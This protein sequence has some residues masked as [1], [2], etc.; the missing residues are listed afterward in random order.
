MASLRNGLDVRTGLEVAGI[1]RAVLDG[2]VLDEAVLDEA[3]RRYLANPLF[4]AARFDELVIDDNPYRR[5]VRPDDI[6][7]VDF[8]T[9]LARADFAQLSALMGHRML[10]NVHDADKLLLPRRT[11]PQKWDD[12]RRF[13]DSTNRQLGE[14]IRPHLEDHLFGFVREL[15]AAQHPVRSASE[16]MGRIDDLARQRRRQN[17]ELHDLVDRSAHRA[18]MLVMLAIQADAIALNAGH[19]ESS[20]RRRLLALSDQALPD[21][22]G[23]PDRPVQQPRQ[24][25]RFEPHSYYQYYL[26]STLALMNALNGAARDPGQH[27]ALAGLLAARTVDE[28]AAAEIRRSATL[29]PMLPA[30][31]PPADVV[32]VVPPIRAV[33]DKAEALGGDFAL[34]EFGRGLHSYAVLLDL[35]HEDLVRQLTWIDSM[36]AYEQSARRLQDG[37]REHEI[38]VELDT[39]VESWEECSTTHVHDDDRLLIIESGEMDFW[40]C[41]GE[42]HTFGPGDM[43]FIP[44]H[45]LHGSVVLSGEC[46][47]HQPV[48]TPE[49]LRRFG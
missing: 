32:D 22:F 18:E 17:G 2:A 16:A 39:F 23:A 49:L 20:G 9:P 40:N 37:I 13:Y 41:F 30:G 28:H 38:E 6:G 21:P 33:V 26:P 27:F 36:P 48:I 35:H 4:C 1:D 12:H 24:D 5:P 34:R 7:L 31:D 3:V 44:R 8:A 42:Q 15:A 11:T 43:T 25:L 45:R 46:V 19:L 47:Y 29:A 14:L 10:L